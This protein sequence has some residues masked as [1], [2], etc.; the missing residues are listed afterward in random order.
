MKFFARNKRV[1]ILKRE[2]PASRY[3]KEYLENCGFTVSVRSSETD[4]KW[5]II[6]QEKPDVI[7]TESYG[8]KKTDKIDFNEVASILHV[9]IIV[10][11]SAHSD[12]HMN[13]HHKLVYP[14]QVPFSVS[15]CISIIDCH[16]PP[17]SDEEVRSRKYRYYSDKTYDFVKK[18]GI[19]EKL[20][21][22]DYLNEA[23][24]IAVTEPFLLNKITS[25]IYPIVAE[26]FHT[27]SACVE[28]SI[29]TA[30]AKA[31]N[32]SEYAENSFLHDFIQKNGIAP[33][34]RKILFYAAK[35]IIEN[36]GEKFVYKTKQDISGSKNDD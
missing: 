30:V 12:I 5:Q 29:R 4:D 17:L 25:E 3:E 23:V 10:S 6:L 33:T 20:D 36:D 22:F 8:S 27:T 34:N 28:K 19:S 21:G 16:Y 15:Q 31:A 18:T 26:K 1:L 7:I 32:E 9:V 11:I 35:E 2:R 13:T 14:V 24:L